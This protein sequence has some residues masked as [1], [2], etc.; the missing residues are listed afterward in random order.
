MLKNQSPKIV[1]P[2]VSAITVIIS[3]LFI[4]LIGPVQRWLPTLSTTWALVASIVLL[5]V[6]LVWSWF[7]SREFIFQGAI[8]Q[9][10]WRDLRVWA[11]V[12]M[13]VMIVIYFIFK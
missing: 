10:S 11:T 9:Q 13:L 4:L 12:L 3:G 2:I 1:I 7:R 8:D 5:L 6:T